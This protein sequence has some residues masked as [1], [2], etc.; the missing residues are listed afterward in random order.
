MEVDAGIAHDTQTTEVVVGV[1]QVA[2]RVDVAFREEG[3]TLQDLLAQGY[4]RIIR[5]ATKV[6]DAPNRIYFV[7]AGSRLVVLIRM[8]HQRKVYL[9][10]ALNGVSPIGNKV[11]VEAIVAQ[12]DEILRNARAL[13]IQI[14]GIE[15]HT[16]LQ[17]PAGR[18][19]LVEQTT[20]GRILDVIVDGAQKI[21]HARVQRIERAQLLTLALNSHIGGSTQITEVLHLSLQRLQRLCRLH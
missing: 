12:I 1:T 3:I 19:Y 16:F 21:G 7:R 8:Q 18:I 6:V 11:F 20:D 14:V 2:S 17:H 15:H 13:T 5:V 4:N 9:V 10:R